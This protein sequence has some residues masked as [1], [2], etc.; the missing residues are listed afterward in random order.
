[1]IKRHFT[2][3]DQLDVAGLNKITVLLDRSESEFTEVGH[4]VWR[5]DLLG[6]PHQHEDK[7]Q[8]FYITGGEGQI[9]LGDKLHDI[10][11]GCLLY[12]PAHLV[13]QT[14]TREE[15]EISY[16]LL[17]IFNDKRNQGTQSFA[18]HIQHVKATRKRQADEQSSAGSDAKSQHVPANKAQFFPNINHGKSYDFGSNQA[19]LLLDRT[20]TDRCELLVISWEANESGALVAHPDKEQSF[21]VLA[22]TGEITIGAETQSVRP[23]DFVFVPRNS[24][25]TTHASS[26][27]LQYLC[28]NSLITNLRDKSFEEAYQRVAPQRIERWK[29][30]SLDVGE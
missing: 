25:H 3:G 18:Q 14:I 6:P 20:E 7:D 27:G 10:K 8:I 30:K 21:F 29:S 16:L 23:G 26:E 5:P 4:N 22:G 9:K 11:P 12:V 24:V 1:M 28:L 17:N 13:H 15:G 2:E 19:A